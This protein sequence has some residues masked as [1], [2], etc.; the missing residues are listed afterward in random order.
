MSTY[1]DPNEV[2]SPGDYVD[3]GSVEAVM[4]LQRQGSMEHRESISSRPPRKPSSAGDLW[5]GFKKGMSDLQYGATQRALELTGNPRAGFMQQQLANERKGAA[6]DET[7]YGA[8]SIATSAGNFAADVLPTAAAG[9]IAGP[10]LLGGAAAGTL[11]GYLRPSVSN[12]ETTVNTVA[13]GLAAPLTALA[14]RTSMPRGVIEP[15][16]LAAINAGRSKGIKYTGGQ[17]S[18]NPIVQRAEAHGQW[19]PATRW[20]AIP[21]ENKQNNDFVK[22]LLR[23]VGV[24]P[25]NIPD[26]AALSPQVLQSAKDA[27]SNRYERMFAQNV[28]VDLGNTSA[29]G[30]WE[31]L[32]KLRP[33]NLNIV[34]DKIKS[35]VANTGRQVR[36]SAY[37]NN[38]RVPAPVLQDA[39]EL[40]AEERS[41][42]LAAGEGKAAEK[43]S[44][45][46]DELI[47]RLPDPQA[48]KA[49]Q[50][51]RARLYSIEDLLRKSRGMGEGTPDRGKLG[52]VI[53]RQLPGGVIYN[54]STMA[55]LARGGEKSIGVGALPDR[56]TGL[57]Q[58][59]DVGNAMTYW[60][61][62]TPWAK[63][64]LLNPTERDMI[65]MATRYLPGAMATEETANRFKTRTNK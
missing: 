19:N 5:T 26:N 15:E 36:Q 8:P 39:I 65:E 48:Y 13:E 41:K 9:Y 6:L 25:A 10:S 40:V 63:Y 29:P 53:E 22:G 21:F 7:L 38:G 50:A 62:N 12:Q 1:V 43:L 52:K 2:I 14:F 42:L 58:W 18:A 56:A 23:E 61:W 20:H 44:T 32:R 60:R 45:L 57:P 35:I 55:D 11:S 49:L 27:I 34:D 46:Y 30:L 54:K 28:S 3:P 31:A 47:S 51:D 4:R 16:H 37:Q 64:G 17:I 24:D 59:G 33:D